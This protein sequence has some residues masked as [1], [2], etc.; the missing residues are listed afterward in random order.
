MDNL[1]ISV[2]TGI[3]KISDEIILKNLYENVIINDKIKYIEISSDKFKGYSEKNEKKKRKN[4]KKKCFFNQITMHIYNNKII[5]VKIFNNGK[6]QMTGLKTQ[7]QGL[8]TIK[9]LINELKNINKTDSLIY[10]DQLSINDYEIVMVN[11]DF[12]IKYKINRELLHRDLLNM[13]ITSSYEPIM[14]PGVN[15][16]YFYNKEFKNEGICK[17]SEKCK[18]KGKGCG[19]GN[20][21][22]I[23]IAIF[24]SGKI[25][26]TGGRNFEQITESYNFINNIL[27]NKSKYE[28]LLD[29]TE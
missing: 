28:L 3:C 14:Y 20:C 26:I 16:K 2:M 7:E 25:I 10:S 15:M 13:G 18:G 5:N 29:K 24:N 6:I 27:K 8:E 22:R 4:T 17:C 9:I 23:T 19:N 1:R 12:D 21:K 11:T